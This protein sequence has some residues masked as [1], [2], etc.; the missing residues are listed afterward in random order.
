[1]PSTAIANVEYDRTRQR[2]TVTFVTGRMYEYI[3]VP[4]EV[5]ASFQSAFSKGTFFN[6]YIRDRYDFRELTSARA[7]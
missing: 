7:S 6:S 2:L 3:D 1:M 5:A 4:S